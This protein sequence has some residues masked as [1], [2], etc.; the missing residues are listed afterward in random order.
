MF[1]LFLNGIPGLEAAGRRAGAAA[2]P[3][4]QGGRS[5]SGAGS[6]SG[7]R[8]AGTPNKQK[9]IKIFISR[10]PQHVT[11]PVCL[12]V[13]LY[14]SFC[15]FIFKSPSPPPPKKN[16]KSRLD[17]SP[18]PLNYPEGAKFTFPWLD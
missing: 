16:K 18:F 10:A 8:A 6:T 7:P 2:G 1:L 12:S 3:R 17:P 14:P 5:S 9:G 4:Q 15:E 13:C 11:L